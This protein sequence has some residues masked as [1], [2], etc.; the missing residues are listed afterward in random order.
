MLRSADTVDYVLPR[1][2]TKFGERG[3]YYSGPAAWN[4]QSSV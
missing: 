2:R 4:S 3:F 1:T